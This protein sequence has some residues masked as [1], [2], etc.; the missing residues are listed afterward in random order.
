MPDYPRP[1]MTHSMLMDAETHVKYAW[2]SACDAAAFAQRPTEL[3]A[4]EDVRCQT[5][6]LLRRVNGACAD[7][8]DQR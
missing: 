1:T 8:I 5:E 7:L 2:L 6:R 3:A 4:A